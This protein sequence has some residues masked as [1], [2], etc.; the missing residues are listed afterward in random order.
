LLEIP[1]KIRNIRPFVKIIRLTTADGSQKEPNT[2]EVL[3]NYPPIP[4]ISFLYPFVIHLSRVNTLSTKLKPTAYPIVSSCTCRRRRIWLRAAVRP[5]SMKIM[6]CQFSW[7][8]QWNKSPAAW[9]TSSRCR[10]CPGVVGRP[11]SAKSMR[12]S[13]SC[14]NQTHLINRT[15]NH[16]TYI[17]ARWIEAIKHLLYRDN[18]EL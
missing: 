15:D 8:H 10:I 9:S 14:F 7:I 11:S 17:L 13:C 6:Q 2:I 1:T 16:W 4:C 3:K 18:R 12:I 5:A